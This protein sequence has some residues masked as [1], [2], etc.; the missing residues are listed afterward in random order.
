MRSE[1]VGGIAIVVI[2]ILAERHIG[3]KVRMVD[4]N[5]GVVN[6]HAYVW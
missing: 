6:D 3:G 4:V 1:I 2:E 5:A